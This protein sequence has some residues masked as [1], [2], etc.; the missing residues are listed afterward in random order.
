VGPRAG[1]DAGARRKILCLCRGSNPGRAVHSQILTELPRLLSS[2]RA[3]SKMKQRITGWARHIEIWG[4]NKFHTITR[5]K[6]SIVPEIP[7]QIQ[8]FF[9][10]IMMN[11][12][13][14]W[15]FCDIFETVP[16]NLQL[17]PETAVVF[18]IRS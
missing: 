15:N 18:S 7:L 11:S 9:I 17:K 13:I 4:K 8:N 12:E 5:V 16:K 2:I 14:S 10:N 3:V 6:F 1:L